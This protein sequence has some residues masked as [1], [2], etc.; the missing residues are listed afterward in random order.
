MNPAVYNVLHVA[1]G[2]LL[3]ALTWGAFAAPRPEKRRGFLALS[4]ILAVV[5]LVAGVGLVHKNPGIEFSQ[6]WVLVKVGCW[7]VLAGLGGMA[8]RKPGAIAVLRLLVAAAV[9]TAVYMVY[10][11]P[12]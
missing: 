6:G 5:M 1:S 10:F 8:F 12:F 3:V 4:G 9:V 2:F 11:R 7:L